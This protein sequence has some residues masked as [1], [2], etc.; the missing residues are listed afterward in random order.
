MFDFD[1]FICVI[2]VFRCKC[3]CKYMRVVM[4]EFIINVLCYIVKSKCVR[5]I[6]Y[7][8]VEYYLK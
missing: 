4:Y 1:V 3:V 7:L 2:N 8:C 5:F 6:G